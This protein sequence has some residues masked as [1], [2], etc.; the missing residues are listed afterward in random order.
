MPAG[1]SRRRLSAWDWG[2]SAGGSGGSGRGG[3]GHCARLP[4]GAV[5]RPPRTSAA[6]CPGGTSE[7]PCPAETEGR[8]EGRHSRRRCGH[9]PTRK[10]STRQV[11]VL[12]DLPEMLSRFQSVPPSLITGPPHSR[13]SPRAQG[14]RRD[15]GRPAQR[16]RHR[17]AQSGT[18]RLLGAA[19]PPA[20]R[21]PAPPVTRQKARTAAAAPPAPARG[22]AEDGAPGLTSDTTWSSC[23]RS[24]PF[25]RCS[26]SFSASAARSRASS[27][28]RYSFFLRRDWQADS[29]FLIIRCCRR[30]T[31]TWGPAG[32]GRQDPRGPDR[33]PSRPRPRKSLRT[34]YWLS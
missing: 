15:R 17:P 34:G 3:R 5:P 31:A 30:S 8:Q 6:G 16:Q 10:A 29:R 33:R 7:H 20:A 28:S 22:P 14:R 26:R 13:L 1:S 32:R 11:H 18:A 21:G 27:P 2:P 19:H 9:R 25:S 24:E 12:G 4:R 23:R